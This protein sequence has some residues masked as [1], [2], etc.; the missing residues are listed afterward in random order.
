MLYY[1]YGHEIVKISLT[2]MEKLQ[3]LRTNMC[4]SMPLEVGMSRIMKC[5]AFMYA[6]LKGLITGENGVFWI[7]IG[8]LLAISVESSPWCSGSLIR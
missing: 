6:S 1:T 3:N 8:Y 7:E 2:F 5:I 4:L